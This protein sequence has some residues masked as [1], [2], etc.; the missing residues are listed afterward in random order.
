MVICF[1]LSVKYTN[2][3]SEYVNRRCKKLFKDNDTYEIG[4]ITGMKI[5]D[6]ETNKEIKNEKDRK[7]I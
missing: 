4:Y 5:Y 2:Y 7:K 6:R 3:R 1:N